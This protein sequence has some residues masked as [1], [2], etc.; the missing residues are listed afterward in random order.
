MGVRDDD[1]Y[2]ISTRDFQLDI[3]ALTDTAHGHWRVNLCQVG[4]SY[5][6]VPYGRYGMWEKSTC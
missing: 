6:V 5:S 2:I 3:F 4:G 1:H